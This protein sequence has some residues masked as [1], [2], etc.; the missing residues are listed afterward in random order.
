MKLD[1]EIEIV[2]FLKDLINIDFAIIFGSIVSNKMRYDSD[3][4]FAIHFTDSPTILEIGEIVLGLE[5]IIKTKV[6]IV[7]LN[8]LYLSNPELAYNVI[9]EGKTIIVK[10][11]FKFIEFKK[12]VLLFYLDFKPYI[13]KFN[14][15]FNQRLSSNKFAI[16]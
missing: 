4:D 5:N 6:D 9:S 7:S 10:D 8:N 2:N 12:S 11:E 15:D 16:F 1:K 3:V 14:T 13:E